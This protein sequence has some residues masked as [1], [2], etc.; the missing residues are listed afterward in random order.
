MKAAPN[1]EQF[2]FLVTGGIIL[3]LILMVVIFNMV[4]SPSDLIVEKENQ[5]APKVKVNDRAPDSHKSAWL[6]QVAPAPIFNP[7][8]PNKADGKVEIDAKDLTSAPNG[9]KEPNQPAPGWSAKDASSL[10]SA[11]LESRPVTTDAGLN[12]ARTSSAPG[13]SHAAPPPMPKMAAEILGARTTPPQPAPQESMRTEH[14][15]DPKSALASAPKRQSKNDKNQPE[16][17]DEA[18]ESTDSGKPLAKNS[19]PPANGFSVQ[20]ASFNDTEHAT[21]LANKLSSMMFDGKR[22]PVYQNNQTIGKK[23]VYRVR[24]GPFPTQARA[25]QAANLA[26]AKV[27]V[28][29]SV[30]GPNQ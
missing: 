13:G 15:N 17:S 1:R 9:A 19:P 16:E 28:R 26:N 2:L 24:L 12:Q 7:D 8:S 4:R 25:Q 14:A 27:G 10:E 22:M 6:T 5:P 30:L 11:R 20:V 23:T 21:A 29:G 3:V 18:E